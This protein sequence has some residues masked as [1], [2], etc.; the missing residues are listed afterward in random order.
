[1]ITDDNSLMALSITLPLCNIWTK[2]LK[3]F[4]NGT[5]QHTVMYITTIKAI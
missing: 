2:K 1:M 3:V 5:N 4:K